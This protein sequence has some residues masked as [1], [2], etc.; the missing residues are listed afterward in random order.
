MIRLTL[1]Y[2]PTA[3][4]MHTVARGRKIKSAEYRQWERRTLAVLLAGP[5]GI[6]VPGKPTHL[7]GPYNITIECDRPDRRRRD[8]GNLEKPVSDLLVSAGVIADDSNAQSITLRWSD[9][10]P[11]KGATVS[12]TLEPC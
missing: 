2:P 4:N 12:V 3:N 5:F 11:A 1:P 9:K 10:P 7:P 6:T 8:L